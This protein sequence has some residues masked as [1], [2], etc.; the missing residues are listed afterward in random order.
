MPHGNVVWYQFLLIPVLIAIGTQAVAQCP[1]L[2]EVFGT[3]ALDELGICVATYGD[4][5]GDGHDDFLAT[6]GFKDANGDQL[7]AVRIISGATGDSLRI[8][9]GPEVVNGGAGAFGAKVVSAGDVDLDGTPDI[10][11]GARL[12][13]TPGCFLCGRVYLFSGAS[14]QVIWK[15][16]ADRTM[17]EFGWAIAGIGDVNG[18]GPA[19]VVI[20]QPGYFFPS[21]EFPGKVYAFSGATGEE[22]WSREGEF[23]AGHF[24]ISV[25]NAGDFN[26]DGITDVIV[27]G[28]RS[29]NPPG[30]FSILSG[31]TG[32]LLFDFEQT[33]Y[34]ELDHFGEAVAGVGDIDGNG[35]DDVAVGAYEG[36]VSDPHNFLGAVFV[37]GGPDGRLLHAWE[38]DTPNFF[39]HAVSGAGDVD[40]DG[41][42]DIVIGAYGDSSN[43]VYSS[44]AAYVYSGSSGNKIGSWNGDFPLEFFGASVASAGDVNGDGRSDVVI[45]AL[46]NDAV[47]NAAGKA[48]VFSFASQGDCNCDLDCNVEDYRGECMSGPGDR[49]TTVACQCRDMDADGDIDLSD[50]ALFA[51]KFQTTQ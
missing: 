45:G 32:A 38:G 27:G 42:P 23:P 39:G 8:I 21:I 46:Y 37:Y 28:S 13:S 40:G 2:L 49:N 5:D 1:P 41:V 26:G 48:T 12:F 19:D 20:S 6:Q 17:D 36:G 29:W 34:G 10:L 25:D 3:N 16:D 7:N 35:C 15:W 11:V 44:G 4:W 50:F 43:G 30:R 9:Y 31:D 14:G 18:D 51:M 47:A 33:V 22:L 24:G